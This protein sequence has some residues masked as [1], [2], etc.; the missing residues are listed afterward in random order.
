MV[1]ITNGDTKLL[2]VGWKREVLAESNLLL[3]CS[4]L[5]RKPTLSMPDCRS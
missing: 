5:T 1:P 2:D 3:N 4:P